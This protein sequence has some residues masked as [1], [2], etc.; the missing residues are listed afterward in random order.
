[1]ELRVCMWPSL[2]IDP[3]HAGFLER[4][5]TVLAILVQRTPQEA[6]DFDVGD[7]VE[8]VTL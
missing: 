3:R 5:I 2:A 1:M 4:L 8:E 6:C 7:G